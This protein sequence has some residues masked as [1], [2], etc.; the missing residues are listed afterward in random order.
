MVRLMG[1]VLVAA[2]AAWLGFG[3]AAGIGERVRALS[4]MAGGLAV[5]EQEL[6]LSGAPLPLLVGQAASRSRGCARE[7]FSD[8]G[9]E[10]KELEREDFPTLWGRLVLKHR[11]LGEEGQRLL[12][13]LGDVLGRCGCGEQKQRVACVRQRLEELAAREME[14]QRRE[15][16]VYR[17]LGLSGGA[18]LVILL[19]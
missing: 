17:A 7:L 2:G 6:E 14:R 16:R 18:F 13:P 19:L 12:L 10:L 15:G 1:A 5:V 8:C 3:A 9:S 11:E 4:D